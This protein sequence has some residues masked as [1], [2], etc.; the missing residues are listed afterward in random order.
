[1]LVARARI[2]HPAVARLALV[3]GRRVPVSVRKRWAA[4]PNTIRSSVPPRVRGGWTA[5]LSVGAQRFRR[6]IRFG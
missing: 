3:R 2:N 4:G 1:M 6:F 5:E